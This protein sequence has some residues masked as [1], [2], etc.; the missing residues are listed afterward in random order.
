MKAYEDLEHLLHP[1]EEVI[2]LSERRPR[3]PTGI[4]C[5]VVGIPLLIDP[6]HQMFATPAFVAEFLLGLL[7]L[8]L[9]VR[10]TILSRRAYLAVTNERVLYR[11]IDLLGRRGRTLSI[12]LEE[13]TGARL[14]KT[15][16]MYRQRY[17]GEIL[18]TLRNHKRRLLPSLQNG[19]FILDA[20][21]EG[22]SRRAGGDQ[23]SSAL[24]DTLPPDN[25]SHL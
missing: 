17:A 21:R 10:L 2:E 5:M 12:P 23:P 13:I 1:Q 19:Q 16:T 7:L 8:Y 14:C 18:L 6:L 4:A 20:I 24:E 9:G 15:A 22:C 11:A 25:R 3:L